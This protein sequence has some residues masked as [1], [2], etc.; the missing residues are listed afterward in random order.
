MMKKILS[1]ALTALA[2]AGTGAAFAADAQDP[3][4][5][6]HAANDY[7]LS[8]GEFEDFGHGYSLSTRDKVY[9]TQQGRQRFFVQLEG[10]KP[11]R[12]YAKSQGVFITEGGARVEFSEG[13]HAVTI[14][15][16]EMMSPAMAMQGLKNVTVASR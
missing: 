15:N 13:G 8:V 11:E 1:S 7:R 14:N 5:Q 12:M 3:A 16:F 9:F 10:Q 4:V 6:V 2:L